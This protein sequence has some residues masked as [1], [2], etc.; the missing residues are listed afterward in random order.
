MSDS[1]KAG[2]LILWPSRMDE[3]EPSIVI[4]TSN[5][6]S[7]ILTDGK[8]VT[9]INARLKNVQTSAEKNKQREKCD[10]SR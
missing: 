4:N 1:I 6:A 5:I 10:I 7:T 3:G 8:I 2:D 9:V